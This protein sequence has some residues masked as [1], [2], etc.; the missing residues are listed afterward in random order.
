MQVVS[1]TLQTQ[2]LQDALHKAYSQQIHSNSKKN[3]H[4]AGQ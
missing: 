2:L 3:M 1:I 4:D